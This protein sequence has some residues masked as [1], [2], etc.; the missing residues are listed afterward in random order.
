MTTTEIISL[1][2][3]FVGVFSFAAIF[4]ILYKSYATAQIGEIKTGKKDIEI[5]DEMV[6]E[7]QTHVKKKRKIFRIIKNIFF[8]LLLAIVVPLFIFALINKFSGNTTMIGNHAIMVV[9]SGSMSKQ[10]E[11]NTYLFSNNLNNQF[12]KYDIIILQK[13][14]DPSELSLYDVIAYRNDEEINVIHRIIKINSQNY[15]TRGDAN[16]ATDKY[17]PEFK[18]VIGKYTGNKLEGI[19]MFIM[20]LQSYAGIITILSLIYCMFMI[21]SITN[22]IN[23]VQENRARILEEAI[24]YSD[25]FGKNALKAEYSE[26]IFYKGYAYTFNEEGFIEKNEITDSNYLNKSNDV[27]IK[28]VTQ[29]TEITSSEIIIEREENKND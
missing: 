21:D 5:I 23:R 7:K 2:V 16:N 11:E 19:G 20:F 25:D 17:H 24:D 8:Y 22:K 28:E 14:N 10:N 29:D 26:T 6:Y 1:I 13:V 12:Q 18:D 3:T 9:A 27:L 15:E 4:T